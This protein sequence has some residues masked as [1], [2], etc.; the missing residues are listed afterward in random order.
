MSSDME[1]STSASAGRSL[2]ASQLARLPE[3][4]KSR[5]DEESLSCCLNH[6]NQCLFEPAKAEAS[7][8]VYL[9]GFSLVVSTYSEGKCS[10]PLER[11]CI[12][13]P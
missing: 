4:K 8:Q 6:L 7:D 5:S 1:T 13:S 10:I 3:G 2:V 11:A 9:P 12:L